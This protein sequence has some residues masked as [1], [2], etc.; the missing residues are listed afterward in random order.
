MRFLYKDCTNLK[1]K[2]KKKNSFWFNFQ[3]FNLKGQ[4]N[5]V[6]FHM[7]I[8]DSFLSDQK[9]SWPC[10]THRNNHWL[11]KGLKTLSHWVRI[12][13]K[14][15]ERGDI[16]HDVGGALMNDAA[17]LSRVQCLVIVKDHAEHVHFCSCLVPFL[18][19]SSSTFF[20]WTRWGV[21]VMLMSCHKVYLFSA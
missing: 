6:W 2:S 11:L 5:C 18:K 3:M 16:G 10:V 7:L 20:S 12:N 17:V 8:W 15:D 4:T 1:K 9:A 13:V 14:T 19:C 21:G